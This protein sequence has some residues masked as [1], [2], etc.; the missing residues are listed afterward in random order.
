MAVPVSLA[1]TA[2]SLVRLGRLLMGDQPGRIYA[3]HLERP[4]EYDR[5]GKHRITEAEAVL[6]IARDTAMELNVKVNS[7]CFVS[8]NIGK[9]IADSATR[10]QVSWVVLGWHKPVFFKNV[11]GGV[12][13]R[14]LQ[15]APSNVAIFCDKGLHRVRRVIGPLSGR[16]ARSQCSR[17]RRANQPGQG[18]E[19]TIVHVVKPRDQ[20]GRA[21]SRTLGKAAGGERHNDACDRKRRRQR[22]DYRAERPF[23]P[24][25]P[26]RG[27]RN[28]CEQ[29]LDPARNAGRRIALFTPPRACRSTSARS[30]D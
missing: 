26:G 27:G 4:A 29:S 30:E 7:M 5:R 6:D 12:A 14:V 11:L 25:D 20:E 28:G 17:R 24:D 13:G 8:R 10:Y 21:D 19:V 23:R 15:S 3:L 2:P 16:S 22:D 18:V 9:D 1:A